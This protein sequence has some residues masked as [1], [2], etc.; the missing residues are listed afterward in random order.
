[1]GWVIYYALLL[2]LFAASTIYTTLHPQDVLSSAM[3][4]LAGTLTMFTALGQ[5][6][7]KV[8][9]RLYLLTQRVWLFFHKDT[10]ALWRFALRLD[11]LASDDPLQDTIAI[12]GSDLT[13]W[14]SKIVSS[15]EREIKGDSA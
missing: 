2:M 14:H 15:D 1:M 5:A 12:L 9:F 13:A 7:A 10:T 4:S 11:G 3:R 6:L 8:N